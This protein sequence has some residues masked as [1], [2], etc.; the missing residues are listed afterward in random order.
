MAHGISAS[1]RWRAMVFAVSRE[2]CA[3]QAAVRIRVRY[4]YALLWRGRLFFKLVLS[5]LRRGVHGRSEA[6]MREIITRAAE[7][8]ARVDWELSRDTIRDSGQNG[9]NGWY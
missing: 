3:E 5:A 4:D 2:T 1:L 6:R 8:V 9:Q 7:L